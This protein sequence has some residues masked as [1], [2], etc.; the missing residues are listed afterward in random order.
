MFNSTLNLG[1]DIFSIIF[2]YNL[3]LINLS[4]YFLTEVYNLAYTIIGSEDNDNWLW[5]LKELR[6]ILD[7]ERKITFTYDRHSDIIDGVKKFFLNA[8][9][10]SACSI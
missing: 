1:A 6:T 10:V 8:I 4:F 7:D 5:F 3:I 2:P 9:I